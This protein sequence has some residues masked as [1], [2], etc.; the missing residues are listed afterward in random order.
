MKR[1]VFTSLVAV[2]GLVSFDASAIELGTSKSDHPFR[3]AQNFELELR[4]SPYTPNIDDE[5]GLNGT[6]FADSFG[7]KPRVFIGLEFDWQVYRIPFLGTIGPG[8]GVGFVTMGRDAVTVTGRTSGDKY[9]LS[10]YP[11]TLQGVL[12]V[13]TFWRNLG[14]PIVPYGKLGVGY[15]LWRASNT[16]GTA[17][18]AGIKGKGATWGPTFALG[19]SFALDALDPGASRNMDNAT[20]INN[21]YIYI[22]AYSYQL[23]GIGQSNPLRV[24]TNSWAA[25]LAFEF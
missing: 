21:T 22:E 13:D 9:S 14:I 12:R 19:A 25:G 6:P 18:A 17:D 23:T 16:T 7:D 2:L 3:S 20:G 15:A 11:F 5:P 24:G 4:F 1:V 10:I 8:A